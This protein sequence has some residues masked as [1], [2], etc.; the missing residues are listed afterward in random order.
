MVRLRRNSHSFISGGST[1]GH[2]PDVKTYQKYRCVYL[3]S[4]NPTSGNLFNR[5]QEK[6][7]T[8]IVV[9]RLYTFKIIKK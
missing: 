6:W 4:S 7:L 8:S 5:D 1:K 2:K 3:L 9:F